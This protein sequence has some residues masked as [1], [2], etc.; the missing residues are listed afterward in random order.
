L[1]VLIGF[2]VLKDAGGLLLN[3]SGGQRRLRNLFFGEACEQDEQLAAIVAVG[4]V[5]FEARAPRRG[6]PAFFIVEKVGFYRAGLRGVRR[7]PAKPGLYR[8]NQVH[9]F[10]QVS[11]RNQAAMCR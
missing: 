4:K 3:L 5:A 6:Q 1:A 2:D 10:S 8:I 7:P 11:R 9:L